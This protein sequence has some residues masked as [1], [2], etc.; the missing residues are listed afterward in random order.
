MELFT[1]KTVYYG[2]LVATGKKWHHTGDN[3]A[4]LGTRQATIHD[5]QLNSE[6]QLGKKWMHL[7]RKLFPIL[8]ID[9][10]KLSAEE[11]IIASKE[12]RSGSPVGIVLPNLV[13]KV[14][15]HYSYSRYL[16]D[17]CSHPWNVSTRVF[18]LVLR[19]V[20]K[21]K[22]RLK[23]KKASDPN[24]SEETKLNSNFSGI[25]SDEEIQQSEN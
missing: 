4:E 13:T 18:A 20:N 12:I 16:L 1:V 19:F 23:A 25:I 5:I 14:S 8:S 17:P 24:M 6:W 11:K 10:I 7:E 9:E 3:I 22:F 21:L 15:E 2:H